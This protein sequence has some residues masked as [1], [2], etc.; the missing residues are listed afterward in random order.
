MKEGFIL[1]VGGAGYIGSHV[2]KLLSTK[3]YKTV[4]FDNLSRGHAEFVKWGEFFRGDLSDKN[5]IRACFNKYPISAVMHF[6]AF[7]YVDESAAEPIKYYQNNVANTLNLLDVMLEA[8]AMHFIFSSSCAT[9]GAPELIPITEYHSQNPINPY[10]RSKLMVELILKDFNAAYGMDYVSLRYFNA[11]GA[12]P[13]LE[14]GEWHDPET[15]LIPLVLDVTSGRSASIKIFGLDYDTHDGTCIRDY[16]HVNDLA[17]AHILALKALVNGTGSGAYNLGIG[18]GYSVREVIDSV[19]RI[20][21]LDIAWQAAP[22]RNG[23]PAVLVAD[24]SEAAS[25]LGWYP[26]Y[27]ELDAIVESAWRWHKKYFGKS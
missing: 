23:D 5:R 11:A 9:Y 24:A 21:G 15:H 2:N 20:T 19:R 22:R 25:R 17:E 27:P 4:V 12:D 13:D 14:I 7:A 16:I 26:K 18:R 3:G 10:G 8:K 1:I 6:S